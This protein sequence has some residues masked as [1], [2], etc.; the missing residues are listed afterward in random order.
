[1]NHRRGIMWLTTA[2]TVIAL[3]DL[4]VA[5]NRDTPPRRP[6]V[7]F[8]MADDLGYAELG[9]YGQKKIRTPNLDRLASQGM[10]FTQA[11]SGSPVC[12]PSRCVLLTGL[13]T[14]HAHVRD[15]RGGPIVG[16]EPLPPNTV[17]LGRLLQEE[18]YVTACIGKW[19][20]GGPD[21][22][23]V[24]WKQGFDL[25]FGYLDQWLA[26]NHYPTYLYRNAEQVPLNN[27]EFSP[28]QKIDAPP[29]D[30]NG[31]KRFQGEDYAPDR[32]IDEALRFVRAHKEQP[33]LLY[34]ATT[35]PHV[36]VQAPEDS[37]NEYPAE[38]DDKPYLGEKGYLPHP[39]P[40][41]A[42]AA[43][44]TRMDQHI[45]RLLDLIGELGLERDTIVFFTSD[46]GPTFNGGSDSAFF[47]SAGP[48][49]GLKAS[50]YEGGIR[51]PLIV[52]WPGR[53]EAGVVSDY[54]CTHADMMPTLLDL[55]GA[56]GRT[57]QDIDG[58]SFAPT[59]LGRADP[60]KKADLMYWELGP[61][62]AL[63]QGDWKLIRHWNRQSGEVR[64]VELYD[65]ASDVS[66]STNL[67]A[68]RPEVRDRLLA[69]MRHA[70]VASPIF[71]SPY[72]GR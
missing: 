8:I 29:A 37:L 70:R 5:Q 11:Y 52:R 43:M 47:Q 27:H 4:A 55:V 46:N 61:Q 35:V 3:A 59:L 15:N 30:A 56:A 38:W 69:L 45:G 24:P 58:L 72:D 32:M 40:R 6:N 36:A 57:P 42:Y 26:H 67:A 71:K 13:H 48:L 31:W 28:H 68:A 25:F 17:T 21:T 12:A 51:V 34:Y 39:R 16:Q 14:G 54:V 7:I 66:E 49:R 19:G 65:L 50:V 1:M 20:L 60:Q 63:R 10:R 18:R 2:L 53:I 44:I 41:A 64:A 33:F 9:C 62:Q 23:G 22:T